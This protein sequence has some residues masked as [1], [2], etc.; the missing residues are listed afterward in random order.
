MRNIIRITESDLHSIISESVRKIIK[1]GMAEDG[2]MT[3]KGQVFQYKGDFDNA[4]RKRWMAWRKQIDDAEAREMGM[5]AP[6]PEK[7]KSNKKQ[8][9]EVMGDGQASPKALALNVK[10]LVSDPALISV[11]GFI[12]HGERQFG[13][14]AIRILI[15][16]FKKVAG[17]DLFVKYNIIY[18]G[19]TQTVSEIESW[20]KRNEYAVYERASK[21]ANLL[22]D[23]NDVLLELS[24]AYI[25]LIQSN[26]INNV[27]GKD[28]NVII[29]NGNSL[30]LKSL[31]FAKNAKAFSKVSNLLLANANKLEEIANNGRDPFDYE[32]DG[33]KGF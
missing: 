8:Q 12:K 24:N 31:I 20:G 17:E 25:S 7:P 21:L 32:I 1:E 15:N 30:G 13:P 29:G 5:E 19:I 10:K 11:K 4:T 33:H 27:F 3:Y 6:E 18:T 9:K 26:K 22:R 23:L 14:N 2:K 16:M 28:A